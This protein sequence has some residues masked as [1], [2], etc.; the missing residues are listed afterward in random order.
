MESKISDLPAHPGVLSVFAENPASQ[1]QIGIAAESN[2]HFAC[3]PQYN[4]S[5]GSG[6]KGKVNHENGKKGS[7]V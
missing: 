7:E 2:S 4:W 5:H 1:T 6:E 3:S